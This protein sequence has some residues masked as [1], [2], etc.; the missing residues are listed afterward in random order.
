MLIR[1]R[2]SSVTIFSFNYGKVS[3]CPNEHVWKAAFQKRGGARICIK[4]LLFGRFRGRT[5][6]SRSPL[7]LK[8]R[9][10]SAPEEF[11]N[12]KVYI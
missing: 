6:R 12:L 3:V 1:P 7:F 11:L 8:A 2:D 10:F 5:R 9:Y 4:E